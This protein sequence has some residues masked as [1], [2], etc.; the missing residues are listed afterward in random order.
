MGINRQLMVQENNSR[1]QG[2]DSPLQKD[3]K[4]NVL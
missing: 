1:Q 4:N 3:M 2:I